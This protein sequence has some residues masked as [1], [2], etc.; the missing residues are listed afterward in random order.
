MDEFTPSQWIARCAARLGERWRTVPA[1]E[2]EVVAVDI[3][4]DE[5]LRGMSPQDAAARW[6]APVGDASQA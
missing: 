6:L 4:R 3:W 1:P 5:S 2:L